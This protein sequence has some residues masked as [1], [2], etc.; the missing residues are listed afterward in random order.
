MDPFLQTTRRHFLSQA[1]L[2]LGAVAL[3]SLLP[4]CQRSPPQG[5]AAT[6]QGMLGKTHQTPRAK[7][8]IYLFQSGGPSQL[9]LFDYKALLQQRWGE[10]LPPSV[11]KG[12]RVTEFTASQPKP[13]V[14]SYAGFQQH[15]QSGAWVSDLLPHTAKI[16]DELCIIR[17]M[18]TDA[19]NHDPAL[20]FFQTGSQQSGRPSMGSWLSYGLGSDNGNLPTFCVLLSKGSGRAMDA[21]PLLARLWGS[22]F[23]SSRHQGVQFRS[24]KD[25]VLFINN[26]EGINPNQ[27]TADVESSPAT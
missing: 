5:V 25:P 2:G 23:L 17:S 4:G 19:I 22:G 7:R 24:G 20:T 12:Q 14:G 21:Q 8:V 13:M 18:Y 9:E 27:S 6:I 11:A 10:Q 1:G 26:P 15:G 16:A 3:A